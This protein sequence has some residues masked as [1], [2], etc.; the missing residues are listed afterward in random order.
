VHERDCVPQ[1]PHTRFSFAPGV[2]SVE[3]TQV[4]YGPHVHA[5]VQVRVCTLQAPPPGHGS[6]PSAPGLHSPSPAQSPSG[7]QVPPS[8]HTRV[9]IPQ[10]PQGSPRVSP[11]SQSQS[12]GAEHG[13]Q[14]PSRH[15]VTPSPHS[16]E[17][18]RVVPGCTSGS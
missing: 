4:P 11:G 16:V 3:S 8:P 14:S 17:H 2:H 7:P 15:V 18:G 9:A 12:L 10:L 13:C 5:S 6:A 1:L